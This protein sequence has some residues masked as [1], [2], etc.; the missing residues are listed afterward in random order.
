MTM[1]FDGEE[2]ISESLFD[3][4]NEDTSQGNPESAGKSSMSIGL[5]PFGKIGINITDA[6]GNTAGH[7]VDSPN[8][9]WII[10]GNL[11]ALST[12]IVQ[13]FYAQAAQEQQMLQQVMKEQTLW[14]PKA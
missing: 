1:E 10:A 9:A 6:N 5:T 14:T 4:L 8:E 7:Q 2:V 13:A 3:E 12:M 11:L